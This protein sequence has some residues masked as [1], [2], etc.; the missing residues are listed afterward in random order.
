MRTYVSLAAVIFGGLGWGT[1]VAAQNLSTYG[2]PGLIDMPTA[3][4]LPD[5]S[6]A[7]TTSGFKNNNRNT[8]TFQMLPWV[9]GSFRYSYIRD[10]DGG[11]TRSRYD[12]SFDIH[13]QLRE[14]TKKGPALALG[15]RDFGGTGNYAGEYVVASKTIADNIVVTGGMGWGRLAGR[16][17]FSNPLSIFGGRF[18]T[19]PGS[20][21]GGISETG[22]LDFGNWFR[23]DVA[24]FGGMRWNVNDRL[25]LLAEYSS[26]TYDKEVDRGLVEQNSPFNF[27]I[28]YRFENGAAL[29]G[30]YM[31]G[32]TLGAQLSYV[33]D[34]RRAVTPGGQG[35]AAPMLQGLDRVAL[36]SW[37][38]PPDE[39]QSSGS[40]TDQVLKVRL[41]NQGLRLVG[42]TLDDT[43]ANVSIENNHFGANA[44][45]LGRAARVMANTLNPQIDTFNIILVRQGV[46][47]TSVQTARSDM[48]EL[49]TDYDGAWKSLAR[50]RIDDAPLSL[51]GGT[52]ADAFPHF[53]Y[54]LGPYTRF[55]F[56]DPDQPFRYEL[57]V[58]L[59]ADYVVQPGLTLSTALQTPVLGN[60][61]D[62]TRVSNSELHH[63][64]SDWA[65][66]AK[67]DYRITTMTAE[68]LWR[69]RADI[70]ARV[71]AGYLEEM[72]GGLSAELLWFPV[73]G[74]LALG[75]EINYAKQRDFDMLFGFQ[76]YD[77]LTGHAS[78][79][80]DF[81]GDYK[82]QVDVGRYLAG[83]VGA[84]FAL[85]RVFNNGFKVGAFFTLTDVSS[86]EFG[87]GS[88]DKGI[89]I[90]IPISWMTGKPSRGTLKQVIR[91]VLRDGGAR[92]NVRNRLFEYTQNERADRLTGQWGRYFR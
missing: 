1:A 47:I 53:G 85:D 9:Y 3:E 69:P 7:M 29:S 43:T 37:N 20:G 5:G 82:A 63:V 46:P 21:A 74:R 44:Q 52:V 8:L 61:A 75:G 84:T 14:E 56:F 68:Y 71:T 58:E 23:G 6:L 59:Q 11:G 19:R 40:S 35:E 73:D 79:Y 48:T 45:A 2:T 88:F 60:L 49:E 13:F 77:V 41:Q 32:S 92:L 17:S 12:R 89:R 15:L 91:P 66:Y 10:Y 90:E 26:D 16:N 76:D 38:L 55:S 18:E 86:E 31:Y 42:Y 50:A 27:G 65:L 22:Q 80:Y 30:Y 39:D 64:R 87:E 57:G 83:D 70:F 25:S 28:T 67:S 33:F 62:T 54:R 51:Q 34:P 81:P 24:L 4:V 78:V 36:A 72:Y